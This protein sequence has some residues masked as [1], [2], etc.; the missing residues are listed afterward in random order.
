MYERAWTA[1]DKTGTSGDSHLSPGRVPG[2]QRTM[3]MLIEKFVHPQLE[4]TR[5]V[6]EK[7]HSWC[8]YGGNRSGI[9]VLVELF[10]GTLTGFSAERLELPQIGVF[11]FSRQQALFEEELRN[12]DS[13]F[14][15]RPDPGTPVRE[16]LPGWEQHVELLRAFD[17]E[18]LLNTG[19]RHLSFGQNRKLVLLRELLGSSEALALQNPWDGLDSASCRVLEQTLREMCGRGRMLFLFV[20]SKQDIPAWCSHL[21]IVARGRIVAEGPMAEILAGVETT[22]GQQA[23]TPE[24]CRRD[25]D[26]GELI[27]LVDGCAG[28]D[29]VPLFRGLSFTV[30]SGDHTLVTGR[31]GC[32]KSTLLELITGDNSFGYSNELYLFGRRRGSGESVWEV[33]RQMGIVSPALHRSHRGVGTA[34]HVVLSGL[35]DSIGLYSRTTRSQQQTAR[36]WLQWAGLGDAVNT[37]FSRLGYGEQRLVLIARALVKAPKLLL[38]DEPTQGLDDH[39][40]ELLLGFL[41]Q[42]AE[43]RW[44]TIF[45]I[46]H[47]RDEFRPFFRQRIALDGVER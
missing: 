11:S 21:A 10:G 39:S 32:G 15:N 44:A 47:R 25:D 18:R 43:R 31:N 29:R 17:M 41:E 34:L 20:T 26:G 28:Y 3:V 36:Q 40:R 12:D 38:L 9:D 46:S 27:R 33:K 6:A 35:H 5:F 1:K 8:F 19:C 42:V 37:P 7:N 22:S 13:D 14:L 30:C 2:Q 45:Y 24:Y 23:F 16:F 4:F